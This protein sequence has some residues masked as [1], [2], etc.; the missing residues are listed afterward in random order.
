MNILDVLYPELEDVDIIVEWTERGKD[1]INIAPESKEKY[2][3]KKSLRK[4]QYIILP[5][6]NGFCREGGFEIDTG[7]IREMITRGETKSQEQFKMCSGYELRQD[8]HCVNMIDY[9]LVL[10]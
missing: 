1:I 5:C 2:K 6:S 10:I 9:R 3:N 7:V 8:R 4:L